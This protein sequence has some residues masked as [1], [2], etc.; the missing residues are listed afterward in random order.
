MIHTEQYE[1][2]SQAMKAEYAFKQLTRR[3]KEQYLHKAG[4]EDDASAKEQ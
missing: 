1:E 4:V 3:Q 2:K